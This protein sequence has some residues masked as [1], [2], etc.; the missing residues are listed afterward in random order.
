MLQQSCPAQNMVAMMVLSMAL[1]HNLYRT[2]MDADSIDGA[3]SS[4]AGGCCCLMQSQKYFCTTAAIH[5]YLQGVLMCWA[6]LCLLYCLIMQREQ[7]TMQLIAHVDTELQLLTQVSW[8]H[9]KSSLSSTCFA[10]HGLASMK[11]ASAPAYS[12]RL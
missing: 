8:F 10:D 12:A 1:W 11:A 4:L 2:I 6:P 7:K 5:V 9:H 3:R